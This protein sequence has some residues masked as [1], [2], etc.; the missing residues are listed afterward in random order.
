[1]KLSGYKIKNQVRYDSLDVYIRSF[2]LVL[3]TKPL[4]STKNK[5]RIILILC[6]ML[7]DAFEY[8]KEVALKRIITYEE[9]ML[10]EKLFE[11][12]VDF[13]ET[14]NMCIDKHLKYLDLPKVIHNFLYYISWPSPVKTIIQ[15]A[16]LR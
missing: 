1:M 10:V 6:C 13:L 11:I 12:I 2:D 3:Q 9:Q 14:P 5:N 7:E 4:Y 16:S 15:S 8:F